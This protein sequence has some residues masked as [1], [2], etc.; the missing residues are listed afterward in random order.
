MGAAG[1]TKTSLVASISVSVALFLLSPGTAAAQR[2]TPFA[3]ALIDLTEAVEGIYGDEG[4]HIAPVLDRMSSALTSTPPVSAAVLQDALG[5]MPVIPLS[6]YRDGYARLARGEFEAAIDELRRAAS[7]DPLI[8]D[9]AARSDVVQRAIASL[10]QG[11]LFDAQS[12]LE[13]SDA[14]RDSSEARRVLGLVYWAAS[15]YDRSVEQLEAAIRLNA[16]DERSRLALSRVL[17]SANRDADAARVLEETILAIP[18]SGRAHWWLAMSYE[19]LN[20]FADA[21]AE[22]ERAAAAAVAGQ[23]HLYGTIGRLASGAADLDGAV[24]ALTRAARAEPGNFAWHRLLA[25]ALLHQDRADDALAE[26]IKALQLNP[27]DAETNF[28]IGQ[29]HLN[30]GRYAEAARAFRRATDAS[31]NA[32]DAQYALATALTRLGNTTEAAGYFERVEQAR[33]LAMASRR[34]TL[35]IDALKEEAALKTGA[36]DHDAA[37][38]LWREVIQIDPQR[39][40]NH[41]GLAAALASA[42]QDEGAIVEY[43][44]AATLGAEPV[45]YRQ[46]ANLY[47]RIGRAPDAARARVRYESALQGNASRAR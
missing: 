6:A 3:G 15:D 34:R 46:L 20:R 12:L 32:I 22:F 30:A 43:E 26:F 5:S 7:R 33:K 35:S 40:A 29:I 19:R 38:A 24:D 16:S 11:R 17:T 8:A 23:S 42:G 1:L 39:A 27:G 14:L 18:G 41:T 4:A 37:V 13:R 25:G 31:A 21:R 2:T 28:G 36:G 47:A 9:P 45:V 44:R 10:K